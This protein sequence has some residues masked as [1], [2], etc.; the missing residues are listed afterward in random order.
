[1]CLL[2]KSN[3]A[4]GVFNFLYLLNVSEVA[5]SNPAFGSNFSYYVFNK[6]KGRNDFSPSLN[7]F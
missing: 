2:R 5:G 3:C 6:K 1:M 7:L 4:K